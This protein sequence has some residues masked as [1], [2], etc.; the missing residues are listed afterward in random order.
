MTDFA[1]VET[2]PGPQ[3]GQFLDAALDWIH[4]NL[5]FFDPSSPGAPPGG[6]EG[7]AV[8]E[9]ACAGL[10]YR[11]LVPEP[12]SRIEAWLDLATDVWIRPDFHELVMRSPD[13]INLLGMLQ[14][15]LE[16]CGRI[17][18]AFR[19]PLQRLLDYDY[20]GR[21]ERTPVRDLDI[22]YMLELGGYAHAMP[23]VDAIY[24]HTALSRRPSPL[25]VTTFD[26]YAVTHA[27]LYA[28]DF[29]A[30]LPACIDAAELR[31][32][33]L[34]LEQ[35]LGLYLCKRHWDLV[36]ELIASCRFVRHQ[37]DLLS[38]GWQALLRAQLAD[39]S[40]PG[41]DY[42]PARDCAENAQRSAYVFATNYHTTLV[43]MLAASLMRPD[44]RS[45]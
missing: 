44:A 1:K 20:V 38:A 21:V 14:V 40:V 32:I 26:A 3:V 7:K 18:G 6:A 25:Y 23:S 8:L 9:L 2:Y 10:F 31:A 22:R 34:Y 39:G 28:T 13:R 43:C 5:E 11:R 30:T 27:L 15:V 37:P 12:D 41:V 35:L 29:G 33:R 42:E 16:R 19:A 4:R 45:Y 36:G 17:D 24:P